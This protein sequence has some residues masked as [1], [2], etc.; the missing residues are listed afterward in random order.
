MH[1][2]V[3]ASVAALLAVTGCTMPSPGMNLRSASQASDLSDYFA[4]RLEAGRSHLDGNRPTLAI[5][6]FRQASYDPRFAADATNGMA[7]AYARIGRNDVARR[8]FERALSLDPSNDRFARNLARIDAR[9]LPV[10]LGEERFASHGDAGAE[11]TDDVPQAVAASSFQ[12]SN[13][14]L[15]PADREIMVRDKTSIAD[16]VRISA[17]S[18]GSKPA[19]SKPVAIMLP[20]ETRADVTKPASGAQVRFSLR[21]AA[22]RGYPVR[23][24][25]PSARD[26]NVDPRTKRAGGDTTL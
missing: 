12:L 25:I 13:C 5:E 6:A 15:Q 18:D 4:Q 8:L 19:K 14:A 10:E 26:G 1:V 9:P 2:R 7:V 21:P 22:E 11:A 23:V 3:I 16:T 20:A 17:S 24:T